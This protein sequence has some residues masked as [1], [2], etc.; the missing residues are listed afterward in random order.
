LKKIAKAYDFQ[1][2]NYLT[3]LTPDRFN[4]VAADSLTK[5]LERLDKV[6][7]KISNATSDLRDRFYNM[8]YAKLKKLENDYYNYK[9]SEIVTK[10]YERE[11]ILV[12]KNSFVQNTD[13]I[14]LNPEKRGFLGFRTHFYAPY[15]YIFGRR[16][17]TFVF[18]ISLVLL[19]TILLYHLLYHEIPGK[20]VRFFENLKI[21]KEVFNALLICFFVFL[22]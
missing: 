9:L 17:D 18:N 21:R 5:Y 10:P 12:Y 2:F 8:N 20:I 22:S 19:S 16:T 1:E 7:S 6:F 11:K 3:A 14:Y 4:Q 13:P 15:K